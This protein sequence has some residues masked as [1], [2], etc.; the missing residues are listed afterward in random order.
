MPAQ[1]PGRYWIIRHPSSTGSVVAKFD[2]DGDTL[3]PDAVAD[4][5][6]FTISQVSDR[7]T[8]ESHTIDQSGLTSAEKDRLSEVYPVT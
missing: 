8:L 4:Y 6:D 5:S 2:T 3:I 1:A 7:A